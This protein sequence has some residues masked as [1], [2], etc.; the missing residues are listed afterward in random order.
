MSPTASIEVSASKKSK[1]GY[2]RLHLNDKQFITLSTDNAVEEDEWYKALNASIK[3]LKFSSFAYSVPFTSIQLVKDER[4]NVIKLGKGAES[5]VVRG[6]L[7]TIFRI[8]SNDLQALL[9]GR[10]VAVK[11]FNQNTPSK[12]FKNE[13]EILRYVRST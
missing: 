12:I 2:V 3:D 11:L 1:Q 13:I 6:T 8:K 9:N 10:D 7:N 5:L 4:G